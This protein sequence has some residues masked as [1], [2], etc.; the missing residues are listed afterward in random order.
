MKIYSMIEV[1]YVLV[2]WY[3]M[4]KKWAPL[5]CAALLVLLTGCAGGEKKH[6][7][8]DGAKKSAGPTYADRLYDDTGG[9]YLNARLVQDS[10][11]LYLCGNTALYQVDRKTDRAQL[12]VEHGSEIGAL[13]RYKHC[14]YYTDIQANSAWVYDLKAKKESPLPIP[15]IENIILDEC[16]CTYRGDDASTR[17]RTY[18]LEPDP[19]APQ[20]IDDKLYKAADTGGE[21]LQTI[22]QPEE[23]LFIRAYRPE[24]YRQ[25]RHIWLR[26]ISY[27]GDAMQVI[28]ELYVPEGAYYTDLAGQLQFAGVDGK[29]Q[30]VAD[31]GGSCRIY[32]AN[33]DEQWLY[34]V[35]STDRQVDFVQI[36]RQNGQMTVLPAMQ[37]A[38][39]QYALT[40]AAQFSVNTADG[41]V[42][43]LDAQ[44]E[45][46]MRFRAAEPDH[47]QAEP[48]A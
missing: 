5:L 31:L 16:H 18:C 35:C 4:W 46:L 40:P 43:F 38:S 36:S 15:P 22:L 30:I 8:G 48:F 24:F 9:R 10:D 13:F 44:Q 3:E 26:D 1:I 23:G 17:Y 34:G 7:S 25:N 32:L 28:T 12:L 11:H 19:T 42:Y 20:L 45:K 41:W 37:H 21:I 47:V 14:L 29:K 6:G 33:Y 39:D 27:E 2:R